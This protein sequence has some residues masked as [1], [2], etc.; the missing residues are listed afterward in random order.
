MKKTTITL[1]G[2]GT[3]GKAKGQ[4]VVINGSVNF[5]SF[6]DAETGKVKDEN[7]E[8]FG[9]T[10]DGK[11]LVC[12]PRG[13][14]GT[15][16]YIPTLTENGHG[17]AAIV[18][19][20]TNTVFVQGSLFAGIPLMSDLNENPIEA[21]KTGDMVEVDADRGVLTVTREE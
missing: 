2:K 6:F 19:P 8:Y 3:K 10:L 21:I 20:K 16:W 18:N 11:I 14:V 17:P 4:A 13:G 5:F 9:K 1:R 7:S 15:A 12:H